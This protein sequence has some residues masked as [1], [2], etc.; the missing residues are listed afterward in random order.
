MGLADMFIKMNIRYGDEDSLKVIENIGEIMLNMAVQESS[1]L[2]K[3]EGS[4]PKYKYENIIKS[5]FYQENLWD[6]TKQ[7]VKENGLRNSQLLTIA[8]TGSISTMIGTSG[9]VEPI[10]QIS[11]TRKSET[12]H[13]GETYYKVFTPIAKQYMD[14]NNITEESE[15]PE[16]F[17]TS[18]G[19]DY[20]KRIDV[21]AVW[22][23]YIDASIS[24]TV[25]LP[26]ETTV[27][28]VAM[29]YNYA[30]EKGLKGVTIF[31]DGCNRGAILITDK[32]KDKTKIQELQEQLDALMADSLLED[33]DKCP[34]CGGKM[35]HVGGC[36]ECQD[37]GYSPCSI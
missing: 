5:K 6:E 14:K 7:M 3:T 23:K 10:F 37:C 2:A 31:R 8:P 20:N 4:F 25:N 11:Y 21:Q 19:L 36:D 30:W 26:E 27:D 35:N 32:S 15:L 9:G 12:L 13:K 29:L 34:M 16:F 22:Q 24:S 17:V 18:S 1:E 28:E 33:P